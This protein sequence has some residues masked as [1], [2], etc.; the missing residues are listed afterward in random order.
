MKLNDLLDMLR[1]EFALDVPGTLDTLAERQASPEAVPPSLPDMLSFLERSADVVQIVG[2]QGLAGFLQQVRTFSDLISHQDTAFSPPQAP[3]FTRAASLK[4]LSLWVEKASAYL[5]NP[6]DP[7]AVSAIAK[8]LYRCPL[9]PDTDAV[10]AL[11]ALLAVKPSLPRDD[12][13]AAP[14]DS[15]TEDDVGLSTDEVDGD[16]LQALLVDA[17]QQLEQ[18]ETTLQRWATGLVS[19]ADM[20]EAQRI[21]HTFK[22]SGNI[23]GLPGIGR[24]AHR[25]EDILEYA[26]EATRNHEAVNPAMARDSLRAVLTLQQMTAYLQ[27]EEAVPQDAKSVLQRLLDWVQWIRDG[28]ALSASPEPLDGAAAA[29]VPGAENTI[30]MQTAP[31]KQGIQAGSSH[32]HDCR[33]ALVLIA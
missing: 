17:P 14:L 10:L 33:C 29:A 3:G 13:D 11:A 26:L 2:M 16:L 28:Q 6:A 24:M 21:A 27:G 8:Y 1:A 7:L 32:P 5:D 19:D 9:K 23:I 25:L 15:A 22:G 18:L 31:G 30:A 12:P 20:L 4:W